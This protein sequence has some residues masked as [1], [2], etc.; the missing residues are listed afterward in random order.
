MS[1]IS[2]A[3][4]LTEL[5]KKLGDTEL[6]RKIVELEVE[7][8][9]LSRENL[10]LQRKVDTQLEALAIQRSL[11][12]RAPFYFSEKDATPYC[13]NCWEVSKLAI[14][15]AFQYQTS[16]GR[17]RYRCNT[18]QSKWLVPRIQG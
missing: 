9:E 12:F 3:K 5:I 1:L 13:P 18:C 11:A 8:L 16:D 15:V 6:Y 7:I 17:F 4:E 2:N 14:H 10:E